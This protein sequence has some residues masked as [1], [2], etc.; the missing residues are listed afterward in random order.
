MPKEFQ[1]IT[2]KLVEFRKELDQFRELLNSQETFGERE[3]QDFFNKSLH[4]CAYIGV[5]AR[6]SI[7][8]AKQVASQFVLN[9][10]IADIAFGTREKSFC[11]VE[12][13]DA[14]PTSVLHKVGKKAMKE[15]APR[16]EHGFSQLVDWFCWLD[17]QKNTPDF[18]K[19]F[20]YGHIDFVGLLLVGRTQGLEADDIR[21]LRWRKHNV[22]IDSH[23]VFCMTYD[24]LY[25]GLNE[26]YELHA[27]AYQV[28]SN[29]GSVP[30]GQPRRTPG[31]RN[32]PI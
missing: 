10:F 2:F 25:D 5:G 13:E 8:I 14:D 6:L 20:G 23:P 7:G 32:W 31:S 15:W 24:E 3:I 1:D 22:I 16:F 30:D 17:G 29:P 9:H 27:A 18:Q 19:C 26:A 11:M 4:L 28:E 12:L 21:R